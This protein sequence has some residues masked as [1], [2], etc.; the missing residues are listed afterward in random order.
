MSGRVE[1][2][3]HDAAERAI[4]DLQGTYRLKATE[5]VPPVPY[6]RMKGQRESPNPSIKYEQM[7][8]VF[9]PT[10]WVGVKLTKICDAESIRQG[11]DQDKR[12]FFAGFA[13]ALRNRDYA[14][15]ADVTLTQGEIDTLNTALIERLESGE[16]NDNERL[17]FWQFNQDVIDHH[18]VS[19]VF[20]EYEQKTLRA[21]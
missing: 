14:E 6:D 10:D 13:Q 15:G 20:R 3:G 9:V 4:L 12:R 7:S 17:S 19:L 11:L 1:R 8:V 16:A 21:M 18:G 5:W 2:L